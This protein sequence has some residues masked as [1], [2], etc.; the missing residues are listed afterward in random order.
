MP[1]PAADAA[2]ASMLTPRTSV[3]STVGSCD[4]RCP[5]RRAGALLVADDV[6]PGRRRRE[7]ARTLADQVVG[8]RPATHVL[9]RGDA[10]T[11]RGAGHGIGPALGNLELGGAT[12]PP[13]L[14][15]AVGEEP[16]L[17]GDVD[18]LDERLAVQQH[19][20]ARHRF[21]ADVERVEVETD[22]LVLDLADHR[23]R[24]EVAVVGDQLQPDLVPVRAPGSVDDAGVTV[25]SSWSTSHEMS[26]PPVQARGASAAAGDNGSTARTKSST[27]RSRITSLRG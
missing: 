8:R 15:P 24:R 5:T 6:R 21:D 14:V 19:P 3:S 11:G 4:V 13:L 9:A 17:D 7:G 18:E 22:T 1:P 23:L 26:T 20:D 25:A 2:G 12:Q 16:L 10:V 27:T